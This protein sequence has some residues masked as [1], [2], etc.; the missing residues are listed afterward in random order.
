MASTAK[1]KRSPQKGKK[2]YA[3]ERSQQR[4]NRDDVPKDPKRYA[5]RGRGRSDETAS[6][7]NKTN[8]ISWYAKYPNLLTAAAS[9]PFPYRPGRVLDAAVKGTTYHAPIPG[10]CTIQW[11]P[12]I[13]YAEGPTDPINIA[14]HE[15]YGQV[16]ASFSSELEADAPD[17]GI[18]LLALDSVFAYIG[19]LKRIFRVVNAFNPNNYAVPTGLMRAL[20]FNERATAQLRV[21]RMQLFAY[22]NELID[23]SKKFLCPAV[24]PLFNRH[25][26]LCDNVYTDAPTPSAQLYTMV[27]AAFLQFSMQAT[28]QGVQAGGLQYLTPPWSASEPSVS[29][30]YSF[31]LSLITE[32]ATWSTSYT[33]SGY[34]RRAFDGV[35][36]FSVDPLLFTETLQPQYDEVVLMQIENASAPLGAKEVPQNVISQDPTT[37]SLLFDYQI[38]LPTAGQEVLMIAPYLPQLVNCRAEFPTAADVTEATRLKTFLI[39]VDQATSEQVFQVHSGTEIVT[40]I[41]FNYP[42]RTNAGDVSWDTGSAFEFFSEQELIDPNAAGVPATPATTL[43]TELAIVSQFDW[44][45]MS[46]IFTTDVAANG[47]ITLNGMYTVFGDT[48]NITQVPAHQLREINRICLFSEFNAFQS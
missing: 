8:D 40:R 4:R 47:T 48:R 41:I 23:Q 29:E 25:Y 30:L 42:V 32:L 36:N 43:G 37:N 13:G 18:Y 34:L 45:P 17:F 9:I 38:P 27:P 10:V 24:M 12:S 22:I 3:D 44:H 7:G 20:G 1:K 35:P 5:T 31:G 39:P 26:W 14:C 19:C 16:R 28:P 2:P 6:V 11:V 15:L 21:D 46:R 33:I